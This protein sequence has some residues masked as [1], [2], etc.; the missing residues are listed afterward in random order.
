[1]KV[2][3]VTVIIT[4]EIIEIT[5]DTGTTALVRRYVASSSVFNY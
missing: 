1:M 3:T 2:I 4:T 5:A